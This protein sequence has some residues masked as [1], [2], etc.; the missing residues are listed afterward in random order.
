[1]QH[2]LAG[3]FREGEAAAALAM[4]RE[5]GTAELV[6]G[7]YREAVERVAALVKERLS[8]NAGDPRYIL[9]G[10]ASRS[11]RRAASWAKSDLT[12]SASKW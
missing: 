5:D 2:G 1:M 6:A 9:T 10:S 4:K 12:A 3:L 11:G 8:A 7:G